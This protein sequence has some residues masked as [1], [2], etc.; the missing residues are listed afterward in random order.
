MTRLPDWKHPPGKG[1]RHA[2]DLAA[3]GIGGGRGGA[4]GL[5]SGRRSAQAV[6]LAWLALLAAGLSMAL[7]GQRTW[8]IAGAEVYGEY[9]VE[10]LALGL[11]GFVLWAVGMRSAPERWTALATIV[12]ALLSPVTAAW[13]DYWFWSAEAALHVSLCTQL[14]AWLAEAARRRTTEAWP[15]GVMLAGMAVE[16]GHL[17]HKMSVEWFGTPPEACNAA[18]WLTCATGSTWQAMALPAAV[19]VLIAPWLLG[20][21]PPWRARN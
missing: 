19:T 10:F 5:G 20:F 2:A 18:L 16:V 3:G 21:P 7:V 4:D 17:A 14:G 8:Y 12:L 11:A 15:V 13:S 6:T 1:G 9:V